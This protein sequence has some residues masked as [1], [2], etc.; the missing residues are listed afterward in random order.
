MAH[1]SLLS[2]KRRISQESLAIRSTI[3]LLYHP[4]ICAFHLLNRAPVSMVT[5]LIISP[6]A[7]SRRPFPLR[8]PHTLQ[9]LFRQL[10]PLDP[11]VDPHPKQEN[12]ES[13]A[14]GPRLWPRNSRPLLLLGQFQ[15]YFPA[16]KTHQRRWNLMAHN[17]PLVAHR[18]SF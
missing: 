1:M 13:S 2:L 17:L 8:H 5:P 9:K 11:L 10:F 7:R 6:I 15:S 3:I 18:G 4:I 16:K 14:L 12:L